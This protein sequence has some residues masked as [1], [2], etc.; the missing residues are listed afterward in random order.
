[1]R[2]IAPM[3]K[4]MQQM[5][6]V[7]EFPKPPSKC[8]MRGK[9]PYSAKVRHSEATVRI[10][11]ASSVVS[12]KAYEL[13]IEAGQWRPRLRSRKRGCAAATPKSS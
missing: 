8:I 13:A 10:Q 5:V 9:V 3:M 4:A 1:M 7:F 2:Q 11:Q 12:E 6:R